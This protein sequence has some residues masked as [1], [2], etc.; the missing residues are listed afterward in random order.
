MEPL[1]RKFVVPIIA[2][3]GWK[4]V[5]EI[6][7][8]RGA[9]TDCLLRTL[10]DVSITV[11]DTCR[12]L[13]LKT[14]YAGEPRVMVCEAE[15]LAALPTL[16]GVFD[17]I[18]IDGDHNWYTV[19][20][21]LQIIRERSLLRRG[22]MIFFHDVSWPYGRRDMYYQPDSIPAEYRH[23]Y[24][25]KGMVPGESALSEDAGFNSVLCNATHEGGPRNGVLTAI[26]DFLGEH[27]GEYQFFSLPEWFGL[28]ILHAR[29]SFA[30]DLRFLALDGY[31]SS[32]KFAREHFP[33]VYSLLARILL[34]T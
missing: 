6:G 11:I 2:R 21:E 20:N 12:D 7:A 15:S 22:G 19:Y 14:K 3:R 8:S 13:D 25:R 29:H 23:A 24:A 5:C 16:E 4:Y 10:P 28:G 9:S 18:L 26:E 27:R 17:S 31:F 33:S 34:R 1:V 30:D 32:K